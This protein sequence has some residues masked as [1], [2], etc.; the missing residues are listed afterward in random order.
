MV[1]KNGVRQ[2]HGSCSKV[3]QAGL[4]SVQR[5]VGIRFLD[6]LKPCKEEVLPAVHCA[7]KG[8]A[9][10]GVQPCMGYVHLQLLSSRHS[11]DAEG[12][13]GLIT[14]KIALTGLKLPQGVKRK[15]K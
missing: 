8:E 2:I 11:E 10:R 1:T 4:K 3:G 9:S 12:I 6:A 14:A 15:L 5:Q 7:S 13:Q